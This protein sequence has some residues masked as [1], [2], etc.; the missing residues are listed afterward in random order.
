MQNQTIDE[1]RR[2]DL[3]LAGTRVIDL[4]HML[5]GPYCTWLLGALGADVIKVE[6]PGR[7][8]FTRSIAPFLDQKSIYFL[9]V[10]RNKR[11]IA[12]DLKHPEG[13]DVL[14]R[15][16]TAADVLVE[17][18]RPGAVARLRLDYASLAPLNPRLV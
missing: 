18:N 12:I 13:R 1:S 8:D 17:N 5:A 6:V 10:N 11:S 15:L 3:P 7:G 14:L 2:A 9:S 4:T 16:A